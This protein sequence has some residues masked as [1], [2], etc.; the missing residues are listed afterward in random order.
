MQKEVIHFL[1]LGVGN[2][3]KCGIELVV[4]ESGYSPNFKM[5]RT[6]VNCEKCLEQLEK[7]NNKI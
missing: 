4:N 6:Q 3:L 1:E 5:L 2:K 7:E